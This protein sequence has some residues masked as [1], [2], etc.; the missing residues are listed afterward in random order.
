MILGPNYAF[1]TDLLMFSWLWCFYVPKIIKTWYRFVCLVLRRVLMLLNS[2]ES[3]IWFRAKFYMQYQP[4]I[5]G[6]FCI[7]DITISI[8]LHHHSWFI[9]AGYKRSRDWILWWQNPK[10]KIPDKN[11][12]IKY[13]K[14]VMTFCADIISNAD[15]R[16]CFLLFPDVLVNR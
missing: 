8:L 5:R 11:N 7:H 3:D 10:H 14:K 4:Y 12:K 15:A 6:V 13:Q 2:L 9:V 1:P 16:K